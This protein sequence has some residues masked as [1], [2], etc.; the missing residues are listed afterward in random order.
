MWKRRIQQV[1]LHPSYV[2]SSNTVSTGDDIAL[3]RLKPI[4]SNWNNQLVR[5]ICLSDDRRLTSNKKRLP[6]STMVMMATVTGWGRS[7]VSEI[8]TSSN[9]SRIKA[10]QKVDLPIVSN[11]QCQLWYRREDWSMKI[12]ASHLCAGFESGGKDSCLEDSGGP[13]MIKQNGRF[14][15]VGIVSAGIGCGLPRTPGIYTRVSSYIH[16]IKS[17][18]TKN[19]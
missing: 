1:V 9:I 13:L 19:Q 12:K 14:V 3:V 7:D 8:N 6:F 16:W 2:T 4:R 11:E 10:L 5:P 17:V 18:L 15:I